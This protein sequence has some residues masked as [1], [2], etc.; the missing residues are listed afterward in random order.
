MTINCCFLTE[1]RQQMISVTDE[2]LQAIEEMD[3]G[4]IDQDEAISKIRLY[5][6]LDKSVKVYKH[7]GKE[8]RPYAD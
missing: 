5:A 6:T 1:G 8:Y 2:I 4:I 7:K 3:A